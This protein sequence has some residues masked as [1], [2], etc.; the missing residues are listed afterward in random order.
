MARRGHRVDPLT[1]CPRRNQ[2]RPRPPDE[3]VVGSFPLLP[4]QTPLRSPPIA[5]SSSRVSGSIDF[6][7]SL[8]NDSCVSSVERPAH[9][10]VCQDGR[11]GGV[12][13]SGDQV[14]TD[15]RAEQLVCPLCGVVFKDDVFNALSHMAECRIHWVPTF[16]CGW[17]DDG[18][19][20]RL[21][22]LLVVWLHAWQRACVHAHPLLSC[23][24]FH[25]WLTDC[26][27]IMCVH[28][29]ENWG[30]FLRNNLRTYKSHTASQNSMQQQL[31]ACYQVQSS[32]L[33]SKGLQP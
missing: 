27:A 19:L 20:L 3:Q 10:L 31:F 30:L 32:S 28:W 8:V 5:S 24:P 13:L 9:Q 17:C 12:P 11:E 7:Q 15:G 29:S 1:D 2:P 26:N 22:F 21:H 16:Y 4:I 18:A 14:Q 23:K 6:S 33:V 25:F